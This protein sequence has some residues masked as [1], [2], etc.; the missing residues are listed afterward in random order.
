M[1]FLRFPLP[2][3]VVLAFAATACTSGGGDDDSSTADD[4][5]AA[6]DTATDTT[7]DSTDSSTADEAA[8]DDAPATDERADDVGSRVRV[9]EPDRQRLDFDV[10]SI[11][12]RFAVASFGLTCVA[13]RVLSR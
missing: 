12:L 1:R 6:E 4:T 13:R 11:R 5:P 10:R 8:T 7:D 3:L 2:F 9:L